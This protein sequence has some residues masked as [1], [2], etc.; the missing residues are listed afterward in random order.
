MTLQ[1]L[2][3][4]NSSHFADISLAQWIAM[5]PREVVKS[6]L[7]LPDSFLD[8]LRKER[9]PIVKYKNFE[10]PRAKNTPQNICYFDNFNFKA[11]E[12]FTDKNYSV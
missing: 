7:N 1:F 10:F 5:T 2:E 6:I 12:H 11:P 4:F 3:V 9:N 8:N